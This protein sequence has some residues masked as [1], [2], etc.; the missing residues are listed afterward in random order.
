MKTPPL[1]LSLAGLSGLKASARER[2]REKEPLPRGSNSGPFFTG[3]GDIWL[4]L[5]FAFL[6]SRILA[7][8]SVLV[9]WLFSRS[10]GDFMHGERMAA[11]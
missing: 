1:S 3:A 11:V 4:L 2:E 10:N 8:L 9:S 5:L 6:S 7:A